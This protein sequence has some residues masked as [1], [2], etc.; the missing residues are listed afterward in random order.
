MKAPEARQSGSAGLPCPEP[1]P[2]RVRKARTGAR[3]QLPGGPGCA[4]AAVHSRRTAAAALRG[5]AA[6]P[7][8]CPDKSLVPPDPAEQIP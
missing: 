1:R 8:R 4:R 7:L 6:A 5:H 3:R 2:G